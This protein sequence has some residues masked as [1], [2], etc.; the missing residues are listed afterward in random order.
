MGLDP[1]LREGSS[2]TTGATSISGRHRN[3]NANESLLHFASRAGFTDLT[4][5]LLEHGANPLAVDDHGATPL[6]MAAAAGHADVALLLVKKNGAAALTVADQR[7]RLPYQL[8]GDSSQRGPFQAL[9][10][11][12]TPPTVG[13]DRGDEHQHVTEQHN[14]P[15]PTEKDCESSQPLATRVADTS[16]A[17]GW[18][19]G[20]EIAAI[21][22]DDDGGHWQQRDDSG[23][24]QQQSIRCDIEVIDFTTTTGDD[25]SGTPPIVATLLQSPGK[26]VL[27]RGAAGRLTLD[28]LALAEVLGEE[29]LKVSALPYG[30][31]YGL[32]NAGTGRTTLRAFLASVG[33]APRAAQQSERMNQDAST[34]SASSGAGSTQYIFDDEILWRKPTVLQGLRNGSIGGGRVEAEMSTL[35]ARCAN[36]LQQLIIGPRSSGAHFHFHRAAMNHL[37]VGWK[38]W[39]IAPPGQRMTSNRHISNWVSQRNQ[40][41]SDG[42]TVSTTVEPLLLECDQQAG[43]V[44]FVPA[45]WAH[46]VLNHRDSVAIAVELSKC[47]DFS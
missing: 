10:Q 13:G 3:T 45:Y 34:S 15:V 39:Y 33:I 23:R 2:S 18:E 21:G 6:H 1:N 16:L 19:G 26:P 5:L 47:A 7:G 24:R 12:L 32:A 40:S 41:G 37:L 25:A 35:T 17:T 36:V 44:L 14:I 43:D 8:A 42:T 28:P 38:R 27:L 30:P 11:Q 29:L 4:E 20:S 31:A 22:A 46:G 9:R